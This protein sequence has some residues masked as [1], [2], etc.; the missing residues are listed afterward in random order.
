MK[1]EESIFINRPVEEVFAY[2]T[3]YSTHPLWADAVRVD[4]LTPGPVGIGTRLNYVDK[5]MGR[6][7]GAESEITLW[8]PPHRL[9]YKIV[10][11]MA[12]EALQTFTA[13]NGG[14]RF[15]WTYE[16]HPA[17]VM[18]LLKVSEPLLA[19]LARRTLRTAQ[20]R[21]KDLLEARQS[22]TVP[23]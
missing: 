3:D 13:E 8:E 19:P 21:L 15:T 14:T 16:V 4:I 12:A 11:K 18:S 2:A 22:Q 9:G 5:T 10:T 20:K 1:F 6:E 7:V 23:L 17:G